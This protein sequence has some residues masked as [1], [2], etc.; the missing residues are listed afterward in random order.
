MKKIGIITGRELNAYFDSLMAY[1]LLIL[2]LGFT[3]F[4]TWI[5]GSDIFYIKQITSSIS[6][7]K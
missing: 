5:Y 1:V 7:F 4:F 6:K 3:G 2:F